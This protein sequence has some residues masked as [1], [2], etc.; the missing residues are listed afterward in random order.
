MKKGSQTRYTRSA[1]AWVF[2]RQA[3]VC[4]RRLIRPSCNQSPDPW[5]TCRR[6]VRQGRGG[7]DQREGGAS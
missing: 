5:R 7:G 2:L 3:M 4:F 1:R 6:H